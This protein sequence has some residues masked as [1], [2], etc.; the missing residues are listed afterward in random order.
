[1]AAFREREV[2]AAFIRVRAAIRGNPANLQYFKNICKYYD[3]VLD[4]PTPWSRQYES[5]HFMH[6][7]YQAVCSAAPEDRAPFALFIGASVELYELYLREIGLVTEAECVAYRFQALVHHL[8]APL[9]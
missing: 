8:P 4:A 2:I 1:M 7:C 9:G 5:M 3:I 6:V